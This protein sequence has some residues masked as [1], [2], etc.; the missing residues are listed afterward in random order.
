MEGVL[1]SEGAL[2]LGRPDRNEQILVE[3]VWQEVRDRLPQSLHHTTRLTFEKA[4]PTLMATLPRQGKIQLADGRDRSL[5]AGATIGDWFDQAPLNG[6][7]LIVGPTGIGKTTALLELAAELVRRAKRD[8]EQP[9]PVLF[10]LSSWP[11]EHQPFEA[12]LETELRM[13]YGV[14][15]KLSQLWLETNTLLPLLDGLDELSPHRQASAVQ[16]VNEWLDNGAGALVVCCRREVGDR[17]PTPLALNGT[18]ELQPLTPEQLEQSLNT[19]QLH[20]LWTKIQTSP[21]LL[22]L[23][24]IPVW[25]SLLILTKDTFNIATWERL[26]TPQARENYL[27]D[28]FILQQIHQPLAGD[29]SESPNTTEAA[30][31][32]QQIRHWLGWLARHIAEQPEN[33]FLIENLQPILLSDRR[34][35]ILYSILGGLI[36]A[37]MGG[38]V[39]GLFI[40]LGSGLFVTFIVATLFVLKR[41]D[42]AI[43]TIDVKPTT[44]SLMQFIFVRQLNPLLLFL[45]IAVGVTAFYAEGVGSFIFILG[46]VVL[47]G[48]LVR[49][50]IA[51]PSWLMGSF[52]FKINRFWEADITIRTDPNQS[53]QETQLYLLR[54][55]AMFIPLLL[56]LKITPLF[57]SGKIA[58]P[59]PF[60]VTPFM[61]I[62]GVITAIALWASIFHSALVC[63]QHLALRLVLFR[64]GVM[65]WNYA[66]F[67]N[68]CC[69]R[70]LLQRIGGRYQ[71][72]HRLVQ[73][74]LATP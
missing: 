69:D 51:L 37:S 44:V 65:P 29:F 21:E 20:A 62:F 74:R 3:V 14:S 2:C 53:I 32:P 64:A 36:F 46:I 24:Q 19:P 10:Q 5:H 40:G 1:Q 68:F 41:R 58:G 63:A 17:G 48:L 23:L 54:S 6:R 60:D 70:H 12:W 26:I 25:L 59:V 57:W 55:V 47:V 18:L 67:L 16:Q 11:V 72:I 28:S 42:D 30:F 27:L 73:E 38:L 22:H 9:M 52:V 31:S 39:F 8:P 34:Q 71:F 15:P 61:H 7:L 45:V 49:L 35:V 43:N 56:V 33:E 13:K 4:D 66:R 50:T